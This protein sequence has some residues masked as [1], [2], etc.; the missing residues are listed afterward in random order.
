MNAHQHTRKQYKKS[1]TAKLII[2]TV[3]ERHC[4]T[5]WN[6]CR[7]FNLAYITDAIVNAFPN[8]PIKNKGNN[9]QA[10]ISNVKS[11]SVIFKNLL[12]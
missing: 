4:V 6:S 3:F 9:T 1:T 10:Y 2:N 12:I 8:V 11:F 5:S 7:L